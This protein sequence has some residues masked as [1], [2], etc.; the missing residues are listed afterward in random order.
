LIKQGFLIVV[1]L[2]YSSYIVLDAVVRMD[3]MV[4]LI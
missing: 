3:A 4:V 1:A 2:N